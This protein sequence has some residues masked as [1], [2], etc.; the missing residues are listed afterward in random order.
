MLEK[1]G[2]YQEY[3]TKRWEYLYKRRGRPRKLIRVGEPLSNRL[4]KM[5]PL[6]V[7][8][9]YG[10]LYWP[11]GRPAAASLILTVAKVTDL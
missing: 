2:T 6:R 4:G 9:L 7:D 11:T 8:A 3:V 1:N 10:L 5:C